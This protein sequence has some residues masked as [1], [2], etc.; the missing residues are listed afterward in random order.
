ML[1]ANVDIAAAVVRD[2]DAGFIEANDWL[3]AEQDVHR[4]RDTWMA[5]YLYNQTR[6]E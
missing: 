5:S 2:A 4:P 1:E 6:Q 3:E